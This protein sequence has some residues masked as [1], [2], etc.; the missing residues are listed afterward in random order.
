MMI[1]KQFI[2]AIIAPV[3]LFV[4]VFIGETKKEG[5]DQPVF[6]HLLVAIRQ[7]ES[8]GNDR[9]VGDRGSS[10]GPFQIKRAYWREATAGTDAAEWD[11]DKWVWNPNRAGYVVYLHWCKVCPEAL[12]TS[13]EELLTRYHRLPYDPWRKDNDDYWRK[14]RQELSK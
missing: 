5:I 6:Y 2:I 9:A 13:D 7:V 8:A 10:R 1:N 14:V 3:L 11:Y 4:V 12:R